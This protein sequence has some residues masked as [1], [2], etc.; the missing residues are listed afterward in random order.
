MIF[1]KSLF[2]IVAASKEPLIV[3]ACVVRG[4][5]LGLYPAATVYK[6]A[7]RYRECLEKFLKF[8]CNGTKSVAVGTARIAR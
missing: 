6:I 5:S 7:L 4:I 8:I 3:L 1:G 2:L